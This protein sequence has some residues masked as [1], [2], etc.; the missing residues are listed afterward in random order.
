MNESGNTPTPS[1]HSALI[2]FSSLILPGLGQFLLKKRQR[3]FVIFFAVLIS[4]FL[5]NWSLV[6]QNIG[7]IT[8]GEFTTSWLWLPLILFWIWNIMDAR[9]LSSAKTINLLP[10]IAFIAIILYV[11]AWNVTD[12]RLD[13]LVERFS[14]ART[15]A[16]KLLNPDVITITING[17][18]QICA[19]QCM[20]TYTSD[21]LSGRTTQGPIRWSDNLSDIVG[22]VKDISAPSWEVKL[23]LAQ[24]GSNVKT[25]SS[26][27]MLQTIAMGLMA[28]IFSTILAIPVS[29]LA[30]HNIMS[31]VR[32][33]MIVYY[34]MR[35]ILNVV[36]A[37]DTIV[38]GLIVIV[39]VGLGSFAGVIA[40]TIHSVAALGKLFSE[41]I[42]HIDEGP[43]EAVDRDRREFNPDHPVCNYPA[44]YTI[45]FGLFASALGHQYAFRNGHRVCGWWRNRLLCGRD[46]AHGRL[47]AICNRVMGC[48]NRH[49]FGGLHQFESG[50]KA[51]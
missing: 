36:R 23:G 8:L 7:K 48:G 33:G 46:R 32:G 9:A 4:E 27:T 37:V 14:D 19:W 30:A 6:H 15:V 22:S 42:E 40:L 49:C 21:K 12:V 10:G 26:G 17:N 41:E 38:W 13:Q 25:F 18:D 29:F 1:T 16:T 43:V 34:V 51:S 28:T 45:L 20:F 2:T 44:D 3:G 39:W 5:V 11:I 50:A 31:R 47:S 35:T 24:Q